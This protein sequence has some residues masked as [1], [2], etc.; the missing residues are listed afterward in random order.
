L[1][2]IVTHRPVSDDRRRD[3]DI[4]GSSGLDSRDCG[5]GL[6]N[7]TAGRPRFRIVCVVG[8]LALAC[9]CGG[10]GDGSA[11]TSAG[12]PSAEIVLPEIEGMDPAIRDQLEQQH[13]TLTELLRSDDVPDPRLAQAYGELGMLCHAY[14]LARTAEE[15]YRSAASLAP[16]DFRWRYYLGH[17]LAHG[18]DPGQARVE[19][20]AAA[21][22]RPDYAPAQAR[23]GEIYLEL[24]KLDEAERAFAAAF[25]HDPGAASALAGLA[26]VDHARGD[27]ARAVERFERALRLQPGANSLQYP[28]AMAYRAIGDIQRAEK[29]LGLRG[30]V[31]PRLDD[32]VLETVLSAV[33]GK[34]VQI[35]RGM[36]A[37]RAGQAE[38]AEGAFRAALETDP[39]DVQVRLHLGD[40]LSA[41]GK[42]EE[43][44]VQFRA[45]AERAAPDDPRVRLRLGL[46]AAR[47]G[48][49]RAA[50]EHLQTAVSGHSRSVRANL[51]LAKA[52]QR[53]RDD[54]GALSSYRRVIELDPANGEA[55]LGRALTLVRLGRH[56][57]AKAAVEEDVLALP[58]EPAFSHVLAR[59][60]AASPEDGVRDGPRALQIME[61]PR[62]WPWPWPR[63]AVTMRRSSCSG[64]PSMAW[65]A[66]DAPTC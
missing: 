34:G 49:D 39:E 63:S 17:L 59:I 25:Q 5:V 20:E 43:A 33:T 52:L 22:L 28:L 30:D 42:L 29:H 13:A 47:L 37:A 6:S 32:P 51:A 21:L 1:K 50:I 57:A 40:V 7:A 64:W 14:Q 62:P 46:V 60:L 26:R 48:D 19:L 9:A 38:S 44:L 24:G 54:A 15:C 31:R 16:E 61:E 18:G 2:P 23:L 56:A 12:P 8:S 41:Q 36:A 3:R 11:E 65:H 45:A 27:H 55:R 53:V 66:P 58:D 4:T 35:E 10:P